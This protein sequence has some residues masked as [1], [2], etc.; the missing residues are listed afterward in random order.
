L[1]FRGKITYANQFGRTAD[2]DMSRV[3]TSNDGLKLET[4]VLRWQAA[5]K[6]L[7]SDAPVRLSRDGA[8]AEGTALDVRTADG[9]LTLTGRV[10]TTFSGGSQ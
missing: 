5:E 9:A 7:W 1:Y 6:R 4:S 8:T 10:R 2:G 3:I